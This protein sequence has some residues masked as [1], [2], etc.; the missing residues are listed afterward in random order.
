MCGFEYPRKNSCPAKGKKCNNCGRLNHFTKCCRSKPQNTS[1][2]NKPKHFHKANF[3]TTNNEDS[4]GDEKQRDQQTHML[5]IEKDSPNKFESAQEMYNAYAITNKK[6]MKCP[7][8]D[9]WI[10]NNNINMG[11]DTQLSINA[12]SIETFNQL[13]P[14]PKQTR[15]K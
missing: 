13:N 9:V 8:V 2:S 10:G 15:S 14:K 1:Y 6:N 12:I 5:Q 7:R 4:S 3:I 11:S